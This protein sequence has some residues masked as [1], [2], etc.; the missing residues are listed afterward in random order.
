MTPAES[1]AIAAFIRPFAAF[2]IVF[3]ITRPAS[4]YLARHMPE[5]RLKRLLLRRVG[6][7]RGNPSAPTQ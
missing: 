6:D 3:L 5:S 2:L 1:G 7:R 4:N